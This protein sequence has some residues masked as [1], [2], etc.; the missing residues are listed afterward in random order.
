MNF[1]GTIHKAKCYTVWLPG[2]LSTVPSDILHWSLQYSP[3]CSDT[4]DN[5]SSTGPTYTLHQLII[6]LYPSKKGYINLWDWVVICL[7]RSQMKSSLYSRVMLHIK[8]QSSSTEPMKTPLLFT[9]LLK[10]YFY[11]QCISSTRSTY[12]NE[13]NLIFT[14][15]S[16]WVALARAVRAM[17]LHYLNRNKTFYVISL[18]KL[19]LT[20]QH[21]PFYAFFGFAFYLYSTS[22]Y[23]SLSIISDTTTSDKR[24]WLESRYCIFQT[25]NTWF[26]LQSTPIPTLLQQP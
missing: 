9:W 5:I 6:F 8:I 26:S 15:R 2:K 22:L 23:H 13:L 12:S 14:F 25:C 3:T 20:I 10:V 21:F 7:K 18:S 24:L 17:R 1:R 11:N 16:W 4:Q 19:R